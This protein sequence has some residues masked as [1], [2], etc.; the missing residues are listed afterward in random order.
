MWPRMVPLFRPS[1]P[2]RQQEAGWQQL[3]CQQPHHPVRWGSRSGQGPVFLLLPGCHT[4]SHRSSPDRAG[5]Q[6]F[7]SWGRDKLRVANAQGVSHG[8]AHSEGPCPFRGRVW[9]TQ[10]SCSFVAS[11]TPG[12]EAQAPQGPRLPASP[13]PGPELQLVLRTH[14][15]SSRKD[16]LPQW[17]SLS[18]PTLWPSANYEPM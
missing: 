4:P 13:W 17:L 14:M 12:R 15:T 18:G 3:G 11:C 10:L 5:S 16:A 8:R 6:P 2:R 9:E 1:P 7:L